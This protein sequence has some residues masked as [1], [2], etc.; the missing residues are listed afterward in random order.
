MFKNRYFIMGLGCGIMIGVLLLQMIWTGQQ[1]TPTLSKEQLEQEAKRQGYELVI[2]DNN[3]KENLLPSSEGSEEQ[4]PADA[5]A[6]S[7]SSA[8]QLDASQK[9]DITAVNDKQQPEPSADN[10]VEP[11]EI[12]KSTN[13]ETNISP[14]DVKKTKQVRIKPN[15]TSSQIAVQLVDDGIIDNANEFE[16][17]I[18]AK[19]KQT[20][21]RAGYFIFD[22]PSSYEN[23]L[24]TLI[25]HPN[26]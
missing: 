7:T 21:L 11:A 9:V 17:Y 23:A 13:V 26:G 24:T 19:K 12:D 1:M 22:V 5:E 6:D 20:Q 18:I 16:A 3:Q 10:S 15:L 8:E 25:S 2:P 4:Q 14:E